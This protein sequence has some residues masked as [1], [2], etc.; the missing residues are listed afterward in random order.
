MD[1]VLLKIKIKNKIYYR[2]DLLKNKTR[3]H[4]ILHVGKTIMEVT[5]SVKLALVNVYK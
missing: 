2:F 3:T 5:K 4:C 1:V